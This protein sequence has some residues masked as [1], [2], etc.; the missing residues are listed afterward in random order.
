MVF[1]DSKKKYIH[2]IKSRFLEYVNSATQEHA[3]TW[4]DYK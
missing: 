2:Q 3:S 4:S 1:L